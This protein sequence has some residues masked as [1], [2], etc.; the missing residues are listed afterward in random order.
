M[1]Y[2]GEISKALTRAKIQLAEESGD[3]LRSI[4]A[5]STLGNN[6]VQQERYRDALLIFE[7]VIGRYET[8]YGKADMFVHPHV[9]EAGL[10]LACAMN[11]AARYHDAIEMLEEMQAILMNGRG[12]Q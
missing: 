1:V 7:E 12:E 3:A 6:L 9:A 2:R 4:Q 5:Q 11:N 8:M 10:D